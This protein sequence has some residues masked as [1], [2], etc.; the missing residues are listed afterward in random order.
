M[1]NNPLEIGESD[2]LSKTFVELLPK[3]TATYSFDGDNNIYA[4][5]SRGY[6]AGGFN[7]QMFSTILQNQLMDAMKSAMPMGGGG[8]A[9][10]ELRE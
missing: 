8:G 3:F 1:L 5:V 7:T 4:S 10:A 9:S 6:K 2:R